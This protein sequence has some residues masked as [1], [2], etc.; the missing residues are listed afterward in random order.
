MIG[1]GGEINIQTLKAIGV[2]A[3][4]PNEQLQGFGVEGCPPYVS[5][6]SGGVNTSLTGK[7][8]REQSSQTC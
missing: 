1:H 3:G 4:V 7:E 8:V 5:R 6:H 2:I